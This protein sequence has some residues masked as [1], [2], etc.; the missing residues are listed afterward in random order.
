MVLPTVRFNKK[1]TKVFVDRLGWAIVI[2][3]VSVKNEAPSYKFTKE[4]PG[5]KGFLAREKLAVGLPCVQVVR[6]ERQS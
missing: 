4:M 6:K 3:S 1:F 5:M 2:S